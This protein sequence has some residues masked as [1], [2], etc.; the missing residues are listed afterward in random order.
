MG[1]EAAGKGKKIRIKLLPS[2]SEC[3]GSTSL[4]W[5]CFLGGSHRCFWGAAGMGCAAAALWDRPLA[6][7]N[8]EAK[9]RRSLELN[10]SSFGIK[11][12]VLRLLCGLCVH[13]GWSRGHQEP[14]VPLGGTRGHILCLSPHSQ[15][16]IPFPKINSWEFSCQGIENKAPRHRK[17]EIMP[18][19]SS[20]VMAGG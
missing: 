4:P 5:E 13:G 16:W 20:Q 14:P 9:S 6:V 15:G 7:A 12:G 2:L 10:F 1:L 18:K 3:P 8:P 19:F 17:I 11:G